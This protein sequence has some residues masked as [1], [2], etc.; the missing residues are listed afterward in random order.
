MR[1]FFIIVFV[2]LL[3]GWPPCAHALREISLKTAEGVK[4]SST[5][6]NQPEI[7]YNTIVLQGLN[8]V[9]GRTSKFEAS[10]GAST[11]FGKLEI[12]TRRC[13]KSA[14]EERPET[15]ALLEIFELRPGEAP[16]QI[17]LGWMFSSTPGLSGLEHA[18]YD[19][20]VVSCDA[21]S[22]VEK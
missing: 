22:D 12:V 16:E 4:V 8:K 3:A 11:R 10:V 14:P 7:I 2:S 9:T 5:S 20:A 18:V 17:F 6:E 13:W 19:I 21:K 15:A 1:T